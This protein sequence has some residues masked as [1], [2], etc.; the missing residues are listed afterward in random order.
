[1]K[2]LDQILLVLTLL[3]NTIIFSSIL[4]PAPIKELN[5]LT[6]SVMG[7]NVLVFTAN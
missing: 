4:Q 5:I 7:K 1:M 3:T 2:T 6:V